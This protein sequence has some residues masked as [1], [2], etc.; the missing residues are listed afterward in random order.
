MAWLGVGLL[1]L[2]GF[3]IGAVW[4]SLAEFALGHPVLGQQW[5]GHHAEPGPG[6]GLELD[7]PDHAIH[8]PRHAG[9]EQHAAERHTV[10][11][12]PVRHELRLLALGH[13]D[14]A[15]DRDRVTRAHRLGADR[16][17]EPHRRGRGDGV[18]PTSP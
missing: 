15:A 2:A 9:R 12:Q 18:L 17:R 8:Q 16:Q 3:V 7:P 10:R 14:R 11:V 1:A 4:L 5:L 6:P 13:A